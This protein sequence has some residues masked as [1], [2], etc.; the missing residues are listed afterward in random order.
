MHARRA[1]ASPEGCASGDGTGCCARTP[2]EMVC[3]RAPRGG[4]GASSMCYV[5]VRVM[6][7]HQCD[8]CWGLASS[9]RRG[10]QGSASEIRSVASAAG[11]GDLPQLCMRCSGLAVDH[12]VLWPACRRDGVRRAAELVLHSRTAPPCHVGTSHAVRPVTCEQAFTAESCKFAHTRVF[13]L[14]AGRCERVC[15]SRARIEKWSYREQS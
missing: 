2:C 12:P 15:G 10:W 7:Q 13:V 8:G 9:R 11:L 6:W 14:A 3:A 4:W 5:C 1:G